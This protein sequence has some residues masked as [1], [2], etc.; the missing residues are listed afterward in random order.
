MKVAADQVEVR[1]A[2]AKI[3]AG[4]FGGTPEPTTVGRFVIHERLG[5]GGMGIVYA[6]DDPQL[7]RRVA[8]KVVRSDA[9][10]DGE[11]SARLVAEAKAM[12]KLSHPN[13]ITVY[14]AGTVDD[15]VFIAM[16]LVEGY[17]LRSWLDEAPRTP[18]EVLRLLLAAGEGL[19]AAHAVGLVHRD[20]KPENVL[21][22][23]DGKVF[24]TDFGLA[25]TFDAGEESGVRVRAAGGTATTRLA[26]TPAYMAPEQLRRGTVDARCD[27]FAWGVTAFEA[28]AGERPFGPEVLQRFAVEPGFEPAPA[29]VPM[30]VSLSRRA[31]LGIER[32]LSIDPSL[33]FE[34]L[35]ALLSE[36][37]PRRRPWL[38]LATGGALAAIGGGVALAASS[39]PCPPQPAALASIWDDGVRAQAQTAFGATSMPYADAAW[40]AVEA[41]ADRYA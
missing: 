4:I 8:L 41:Q 28:L 30:S 3:W 37:R 15:Q 1:R 13:V 39:D 31:R 25:R 10:L 22:S 29:S 34:S 24:V 12:A 27:Q 38:P 17:T 36:L 26:G 5:A 23:R 16:E 9:S 7:E 18:D 19:A 40:S 11:G 20:F 32:A 21:V 6:A 33:R 2:R 35:G 14:E